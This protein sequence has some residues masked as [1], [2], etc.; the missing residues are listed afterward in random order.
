M[1]NQFMDRKITVYYSD[2]SKLLSNTGML[3]QYD[4]KHGIIKLDVNKKDIL[5]PL[6]SI[7]K[8]EIVELEQPVS[9]DPE[10]IESYEHRGH[11]YW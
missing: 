8:I 1:L 5:F 3:I 6:C 2:G 7:T 4:A 11:D 9:Y 10:A